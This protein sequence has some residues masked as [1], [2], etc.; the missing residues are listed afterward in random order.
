MG[1]RR[2]PL[3]MD[4]P[5]HSRCDTLKNHHYSKTKS[6]E[7]W[8]KF[9][10]LHQQWW[11]LQMNEKFSSGTKKPN[12]QITS[13]SNI[14]HLGGVN[15]LVKVKRKETVGELMHCPED[16]R[17]RRQ[18][19]CRERGLISCLMCKWQRR[20]DEVDVNKQFLAILVL[21]KQATRSLVLKGQSPKYP[22]RMDVFWQ[23]WL[24]CIAKVR[25]LSSMITAT[26]PRRWS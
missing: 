18:W 26:S 12:K 8:S 22:L 10:A 20:A 23:V 17:C 3:K 25:Y 16:K 19:E 6:A 21:N 11:R 4:A 13:Y 1:R 14:Q 5:C 9:A 15:K 7:H 2:W 24:I